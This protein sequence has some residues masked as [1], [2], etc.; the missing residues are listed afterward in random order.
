MTKTKWEA[1]WRTGRENARRLRNMSQY[2]EITTGPKLYGALQRKHV[3]CIARLCTGHCHLNEYL[4]R[5]N[6]IECKNH[7][8]S[9]RTNLHR[10]NTRIHIHLPFP[11]QELL[12]VLHTNDSLTLAHKPPSDQ[13]S[14]PHPPP[15]SYSGIS[16][17]LSEMGVRGDRATGCAAGTDL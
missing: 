2:P 17:L 10:I 1:K 12:R 13:H 3:I 7:S 5:F 4:H 16:T 9:S 14:D 8:T 6:I 11:I 15:T